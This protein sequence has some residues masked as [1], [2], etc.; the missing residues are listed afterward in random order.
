MNQL[1]KDFSY[2]EVQFQ[3]FGLTVKTS[4]S[5]AENV[6]IAYE[7]PDSLYIIW[8]VVSKALAFVLTGTAY[9]SSHCSR[10][11]LGPW[12]NLCQCGMYSEEADASSRTPGRV[13]Q[14]TAVSNI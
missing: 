1:G 7:N 5:G 10:F 3:T 8:P 12:W 2:K 14:G 11:H 13:I 9:S 4:C 6:K